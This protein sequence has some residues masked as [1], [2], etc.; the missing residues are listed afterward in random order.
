MKEKLK[1]LY[2]VFTAYYLWFILGIV[3][4]KLIDLAQYLM[5]YP[6]DI[7]FYTGLFI[8]TTCIGAIGYAIYSI[9]TNNLKNKKNEN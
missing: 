3:T 9:I 8:Y 4:V 7:A 5:T 1:E 2:K 6:N